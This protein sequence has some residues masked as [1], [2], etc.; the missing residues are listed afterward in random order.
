[1]LSMEWGKQAAATLPAM[2]AVSRLCILWFAHK[3][4]IDY[5]ISRGT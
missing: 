2:P 1:M 5:N 3:V 4:Q